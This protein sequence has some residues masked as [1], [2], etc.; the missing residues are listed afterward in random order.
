MYGQITMVLFIVLT[1]IRLGLLWLRKKEIG[2][3]LVYLAA[4]LVGVVLVAYTGHLGGEMVHP[5]RS[6]F[7]QFRGGNG[8]FP[9]GEGSGSGQRQNRQNRQGQQQQQQQPQ[10][11]SDASAATQS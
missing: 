9:Q 2:G 6:N 7:Q 5:D 8:N 4:A 3:N 10:T 1:V 11:Q